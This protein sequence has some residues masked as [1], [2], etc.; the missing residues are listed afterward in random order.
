MSKEKQKI[1]H[2]K[3]YIL[4][5]VWLSLPASSFFVPQW[6][7][8]TVAAPQTVIVKMLDTPPSFDPKTITVSV[9]TTVEW[10]NV[11]NSVHHATDNHEMAISGGDVASPNGASIFDSGFLRPGETFTY[12]FIK[13]G[14]YKYV[15]VA[16]ETSGMT[17]EVVVR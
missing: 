1:M 3:K 11:G 15:C 14:V 8:S 4:F 10:E 16:H 12:T 6:V 2:S 17:G 7:S 9:G 13:P 5:V